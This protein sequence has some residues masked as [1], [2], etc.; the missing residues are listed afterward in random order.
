MRQEHAGVARPKQA[1]QVRRIVRYRAEEWRGIPHWTQR[2]LG[3]E[4]RQR[5]PGKGGG[6]VEGRSG[7]QICLDLRHTP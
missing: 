2:L 3:Y 7:A 5:L 1:V 6:V 4:Q